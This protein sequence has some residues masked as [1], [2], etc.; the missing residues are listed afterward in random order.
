[1]R[2]VIPTIDVG[3]WIQGKANAEQKRAIAEK[4]N[5]AASKF[6][7]L[8]IKNHGI[9]SNLVEKVFRNLEDFFALPTNWKRKIRHEGECSPRGYLGMFEQGG[10]AVDSTDRR[11]GAQDTKLLDAK[12]L[13]TMGAWFADKEKD[14]PKYDPYFFVP[15]KFP[16]FPT[17]EKSNGFKQVMQLYYD[18]V[19]N[20]SQKFYQIVAKALGKPEDWFKEKVD[21]GMN[22]LNCNRYPKWNSEFAKGQMGIGEHTDYEMITMLLQ[23]NKTAGLE[24]YIDGSGWTSI[25]PIDG[26]IVV[27]F[28]DLLARWTN[29]KWRSTVHR[30]KNPSDIQ[31]ISLAYFSCCNYNARVDPAD[32]LKYGEK[33][34]YK[35]LIAGEHMR[36]RISNG[37]LYDSKL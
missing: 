13:Y 29:N 34:R 22:S 21:R 9:P 17:P 5:D 30:A 8:R 10:Y 3:P 25:E 33:A 19:E 7:F 14:S 32:F 37:N 16:R 2:T 35:P 12:E 28:G 6:G 27:N 31:R 23:D 15:N 36:K 24:I 1:M 18:S 11:E 4:V 26:T 20:L